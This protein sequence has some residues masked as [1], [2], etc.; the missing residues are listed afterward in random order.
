MNE[1]HKNQL[2][3]NLNLRQAM[4][5][6]E[7]ELRALASVK[8]PDSEPGMRKSAAILT[9]VSVQNPCYVIVSWMH[10]ADVQPTIRWYHHSEVVT[11]MDEP[12]VAL[13]RFLTERKGAAVFDSLSAADR[14][15]AAFPDHD[16]AI[17]V[18]TTEEDMRRYR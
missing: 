2:K 8:P 18:V 6:L 17:I 10:E 15:V 7:D 9:K 4:V 3:A 5:S 12:P 11:W 14:V 16:C 1:Q 13:D